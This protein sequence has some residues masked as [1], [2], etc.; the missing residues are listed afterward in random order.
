MESDLLQLFY[1]GKTVGVDA[2]EEFLYGFLEEKLN[3]TAEDGSVEEIADEVLDLFESCQSGNFSGVE[4]LKKLYDKKHPPDRPPSTPQSIELDEDSDSEDDGD[5][6]EEGEE[7]NSDSENETR[8]GGEGEK[9]ETV[10]QRRG[11][12]DEDGWEVV[13]HKKGRG[14]REK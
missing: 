2:I 7:G 13:T 8:V 10:P 12:V 9:K 4:E 6:G 11:Q 1:K 5:E 3:T 14:R